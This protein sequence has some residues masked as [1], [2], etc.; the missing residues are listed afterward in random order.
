MTEKQASVWVKTN[1]RFAM[2]QDA[3]NIV[4]MAA[5]KAGMELT[6]EQADFYVVKAAV[7]AML[8]KSAQATLNDL[9]TQMGIDLDS[10]VARAVQK[11][12]KDFASAIQEVF[13]LL[14][15]T[16]N[17]LKRTRPNM[18]TPS[19]QPRPGSENWTTIK[20]L[21]K[22]YAHEHPEA[23]FEGTPK[24]FQPPQPERTRGYIKPR[25]DAPALSV[26]PGPWQGFH[27]RVVPR[28]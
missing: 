17:G 7:K 26:D 9:I 22:Q 15:Q 10:V 8:T 19:F 3:R 23:I 6:D 4:R 1:C 18:V 20:S 16:S 28:A 24:G 21:V 14:E 13:T 25:S 27:P 2:V 11:H 12:K 5:S